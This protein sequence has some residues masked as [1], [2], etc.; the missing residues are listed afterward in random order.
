MSDEEIS[1]LSNEQIEK[2]EESAAEKDAWS[3]CYDI[4]QRVDGAP[5]PHRTVE[6]YVTEKEKDR[7]LTMAST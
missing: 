1:A 6:S 7:S 4:A 3:C 2:L 5:G